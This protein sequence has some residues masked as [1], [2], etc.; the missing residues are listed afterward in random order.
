[1][2]LCIA[3]SYH[4]TIVSMPTALSDE[5]DDDVWNALCNATTEE[6]RLEEAI[7]FMRRR[8]GSMVRWAVEEGLLASDAA[9]PFVSLAHCAAMFDEVGLLRFLLLENGVDP[10]T[11]NGCRKMPLHM[12]ICLEGEAAALFLIHE[13]PGCDL[14]APDRCGVTPLMAAVGSGM[15]G[16]VKA[17]VGKGVDV[18]GNG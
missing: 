2:D 13:A 14:E 4:R 15:L 12:A 8:R 16:V 5:S 10:N 11:K 1:M 3:T 7:E 17:L 9:V 18:K 6:D